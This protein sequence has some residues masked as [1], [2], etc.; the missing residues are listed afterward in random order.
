MVPVGGKEGDSLRIKGTLNDQVE[1]AALRCGEPLGALDVFVP[2]HDPGDV[3][4]FLPSINHPA[5]NSES[6]HRQAFFIKTA[7]I[8]LRVVPAQRSKT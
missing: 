1:S 8:R 6:V 5:F 2:H 4:S 3:S 7:F